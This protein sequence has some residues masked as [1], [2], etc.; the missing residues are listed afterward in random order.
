MDGMG[1]GSSKKT[2][3]SGCETFC[4]MNICVDAFEVKPVRGQD[5]GDGGLNKWPEN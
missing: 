5:V 2:S 3:M 1:R 4:A